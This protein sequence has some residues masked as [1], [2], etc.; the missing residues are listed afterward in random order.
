MKIRNSESSY[1]KWS[2]ELDHVYVIPQ[3]NNE[4]TLWHVGRKIV[5]IRAKAYCVTSLVIFLLNLPEAI[6]CQD[7]N[8]PITC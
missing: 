1:N 6:K 7:F 5:L 4:Q 3:T 8:P 2:Q